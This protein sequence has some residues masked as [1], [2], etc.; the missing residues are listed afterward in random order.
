M[1]LDLPVSTRYAAS[2][3]CRPLSPLSSFFRSRPGSS[4]SG[5]VPRVREEG[6]TYGRLT[7]PGR[8]FASARGFVAVTPLTSVVAK[9]GLDLVEETEGVA[10]SVLHSGDR[11]KARLVA[12]EGE[13]GFREFCGDYK[14]GPA[15]IASASKSVAQYAAKS[16]RGI[17]TPTYSD[18]GRSAPT[19]PYEASLFAVSSQPLVYFEGGAIELPVLSDGM[20]DD[21]L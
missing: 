8:M 14:D 17:L 3:Y 10:E 16:F 7:S 12:G 11:S 4:L 5:V 2:E 6:D 13:I 19:P 20:S 15:E 18:A 1:S 9:R 21:E